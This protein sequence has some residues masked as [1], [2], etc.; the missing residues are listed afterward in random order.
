MFNSIRTRTP[1]QVAADE[2]NNNWAA[3]RRALRPQAAPT[4]AGSSRLSDVHVPDPATERARARAQ[5][6]IAAKQHGKIT[7]AAERAHRHK[8]L[9]QFYQGG[10]QMMDL[11][12]RSTRKTPDRECTAQDYRLVAR[13]GRIAA[14]DFLS[15]HV[16]SDAEAVTILEFMN[17]QNPPVWPD[18]NA[19]LVCMDLLNLEGIIRPAIVNQPVTEAEPAVEGNPYKC[20]DF[21]GSDY[22]RYERQQL[23]RDHD[24]EHTQVFRAGLNAAAAELGVG[25]SEADVLVIR[26]KCSSLPYH[27]WTPERIANVA[28]ATLG[29]PTAI[30]RDPE[31]SLSGTEFLQAHRLGSS[32]QREGR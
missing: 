6:E 28:L 14:D 20:S 23:V 2:A 8:L 7:K 4:V 19:W 29:G 21:S 15:P 12:N 13:M 24:R 1:E 22:A 17:V 25:I 5:A 11:L 26:E 31:D 27:Q 10:P 32:V 16:L 9:T 30:R 18:G 3:S